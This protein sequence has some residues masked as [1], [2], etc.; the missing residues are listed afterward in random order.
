[1]KLW[2]GQVARKQRK[3]MTAV[4]TFGAKKSRA[5]RSVL[6]IVPGECSED[7]IE[8]ARELLSVFVKGVAG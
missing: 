8:D 1:M 7:E 2:V 3:N 6:K 4:L 5:A